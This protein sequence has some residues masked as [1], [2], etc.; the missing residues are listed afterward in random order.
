MATSNSYN[1]TVTRNEVIEFALRKIK[2]LKRGFTLHAEDISDAAFALNMIIKQWPERS[3]GAPSLKMWLRKRLKLIFASGQYK[4]SIPGDHIVETD[5]LVTTTLTAAATA[6]TSLTVASI[7]RITNGDY[8]GVVNTSG[9]IT[10]TTVNGVPSGT[11]VVL[12][13]AVTAANG[14]VCYFYTTA[15]VAPLHILG[16]NLVDSGGN[17]IPMGKFEIGEYWG[18]SN[19]DAAG[20][21]ANIYVERQRDSLDLYFD[22]AINDVDYTVNLLAHYPIQDF[23]ATSDNPDF[24]TQWYRALGYMLALDMAVE[25]GVP[26]TD[27][28][29]DL[30]NGAL[31]IAKG[32]DPETSDLTFQASE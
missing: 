8:A 29:R 9:D 12:T 11:T 15:A 30:A 26:I 17:E 22:Q 19:K 4:Y 31:L 20:V 28:L 6:T 24:P 27:D 14:A 1:F 16:A 7:S 2:V 18:L 23:D 21:P 13:D 3:D 5:E 10:W 25:Y 32:S